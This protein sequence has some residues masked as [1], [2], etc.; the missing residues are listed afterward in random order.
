MEIKHNVDKM[1]ASQIM[2]A[3]QDVKEEDLPITVKSESG[4]MT[5]KTKEDAERI[6]LG[7]YMA[8]TMRSSEEVDV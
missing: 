4:T 2:L 8:L 1:R 5:I 7:M 3:L 6:S